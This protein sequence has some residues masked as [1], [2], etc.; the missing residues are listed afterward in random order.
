MRSAFEYAIIRVVPHVEREEFLN[1]GVVLFSPKAELL[2]A[3]LEL[4]EARLLALASDADLEVVRTHLAAIAHVCAG[5]TDAGA[6]AA[7]S[8][9]ERFQWLVSPRST[10]LQTSSPHG[11]VMDDVETTLSRIM[12][13]MVRAP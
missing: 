12:Q 9:R 2:V 1:V 6:I 8:Q 3:R 10:I 13:T 4:D 7:L 11:G 5:T